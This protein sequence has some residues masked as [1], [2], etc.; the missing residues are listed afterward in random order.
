MTIGE[1][2]DVEQTLG[3]KLSAEWKILSGEFTGERKNAKGK[4]TSVTINYRVT[5]GGLMVKQLK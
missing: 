2:D 1:S 4:T 5:T 3:A